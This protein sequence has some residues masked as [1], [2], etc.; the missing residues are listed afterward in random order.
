MVTH[1]IGEAISM[2]NKIIILSNYINYVIHFMQYWTNGK[3]E[4]DFYLKVTS[5]TINMYMSSL[6][7]TKDKK[8]VH[9][10]RPVFS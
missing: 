6:K 9:Q 5:S 1:D 3:Y 7:F 10:L 2:A 8:D 4:P